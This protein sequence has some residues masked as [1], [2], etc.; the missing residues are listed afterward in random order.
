M[1]IFY[2]EHVTTALKLCIAIVQEHAPKLS[3]LMGGGTFLQMIDVS[4]AEYAQCL[5]E[6]GGLDILLQMLN[7]P[8][9]EN[10]S[11]EEL[12]VHANTMSLLRPFVLEHEQVRNIVFREIATLGDK[13]YLRSRELAH[14]K[15]LQL[16]ASQG[17]I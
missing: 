16:F 4:D 3:I 15:I 17:L 10:L 2:L 11:A 6:H 9:P 12:D 14:M 7:M 1:F 13:H 5:M 8:L